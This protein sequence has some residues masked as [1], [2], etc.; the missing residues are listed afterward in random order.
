MPYQEGIYIDINAVLRQQ[1]YW[2]GLPT[3]E[4]LAAYIRFNFGWPVKPPS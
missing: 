1:M 3:N 2:R 4:T